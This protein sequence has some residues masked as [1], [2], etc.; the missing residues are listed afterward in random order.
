MLLVTLDG[1]SSIGRSR[2]RDCAGE[3]SEVS[4]YTRLR[5]ENASDL[6]RFH[7]LT[8]F[9][10]SLS[11]T[12]ATLSM[13]ISMG[14]KKNKTL[15]YHFEKAYFSDVHGKDDSGYSAVRRSTHPLVVLR[16][17]REAS[18]LSLRSGKVEGR[19]RENRLAMAWNVSR[20]C[21]QGS[22]DFDQWLN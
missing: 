8:L 16:R 3:A 2:L 21:E 22:A 6:L 13:S 17:P 20:A 11:E 7:E 1:R 5:T 14:Q 10:V 18:G 4:A 12:S 9:I 15:W 19:F